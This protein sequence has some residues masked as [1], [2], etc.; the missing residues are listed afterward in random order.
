MNNDEIKKQFKLRDRVYRA[1]SK[2][3]NIRIS[4]IKNSIVAR[5]AQKKHNLDFISATLLSKLMSGASLI[6]SFLKGE[7]RIILETEGSGHISRMYAEALQLGEIR[8]FV[9]SD[10]NIDT[11]KF[12]DW[13]NALGIG[14]FKVKKILYDK[15][16]ATEGVVPIQI[17]DIS[18]DL[19]FYFTQSEQIPTAVR[20]D[21]C[22]DDNGN[23]EHSGGIIIQALPGAKED[24]LVKITVKLSEM[25]NI[26]EFFKKDLMPV[27]IL[28]EILPFEFNT[29][30][31][32]QVDF[33]CR[34]SLEHFK[35]K[36][37]TIGIDE[38]K[39][40]HKQNQNELVCQYCNSKY[41][42]QKEDFDG[43]ITELIAQSN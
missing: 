41:Y 20:L 37:L 28:N 24:D 13:R 14:L 35:S 11:E 38:I 12:T 16:E 3:G 4:I 15:S 7:E 33:L 21:V 17:G 25:E 36:I 29:I 31:N 39:D 26:T 19:A 10:D 8:G 1:H 30:S 22:L 18:T 6:A 5:T 23:I 42:L 2:D 32:K 9:V 40:M 27:D 34:C 43:M